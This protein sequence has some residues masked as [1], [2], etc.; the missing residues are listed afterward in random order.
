[1]HK[2]KYRDREVLSDDV[3]T[4]RCTAIARGEEISDDVSK[5]KLHSRLEESVLGGAEVEAEDDVD[6]NTPP[7]PSPLKL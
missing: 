5:I 6:F 7:E 1:M 2:L 4:S 3:H